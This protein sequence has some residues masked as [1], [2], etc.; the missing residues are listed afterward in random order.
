MPIG[1][2]AA[3]TNTFFASV[4]SLAW[5]ATVAWTQWLRHRFDRPSA[6]GSLGDLTES[7]RLRQLEAAIDAISVDFERMAEA[8]RFTV[9][10]LD[11]RLPIRSRTR[12]AFLGLTPAV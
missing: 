3:I 5:S 7:P 4:A 9:R 11:E 2:N 1:S 6:P 10:L 12:G 8:Q